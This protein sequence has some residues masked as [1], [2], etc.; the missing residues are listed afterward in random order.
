MI[1][2][3]GLTRD[4]ACQLFRVILYKEA[5]MK[6]ILFLL[7]LFFA[8]LHSAELKGTLSGRLLLTHSPYHATDDITILPGDSLVIDPGVILQFD[9]TVVFKVEGK[10]VAR[11]STT[12][13]ILFTLSA[14]IP[15]GAAWE[16]IQFTNRS[17]HTSVLEFCRIEYARRGVSI[18]SVSPRI[19]HS[20]IINNAMDGILCQVSQSVFSHN[21]IKENG[22]DGIHALAFSGTI[23]NNE[24]IANKGDGISLHKSSGLVAGN[25][26]S[27]NG[28]DGIFCKHSDNM[29]RDNRISQNLDD[30]IL[31]KAASPKILNN[32]LVRNRFGLFVYN[33]AAPVLVNNTIVDNTYGLYA[34]NGATLK[35]DNSIVWRNQ[36][37]VYTDSL[38][39]AQIT[40][41]NI[42]GGYAGKGNFE[43]DPKFSGRE[44]YDLLPGSPCFGRGN[45][46]P[47][48]DDPSLEQKTIGAVFE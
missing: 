23:E 43:A 15:V 35:L 11:G 20:S 21:L 7:C 34:R 36:T 33:A 39:V 4:L 6:K 45:P 47:L 16:G 42:Q 3:S 27:L 1:I 17:D 28:D 38:S 8:A 46:V 9:S 14:K 37:S 2:L 44:S 26:L 12:K 18:F 22:R 48:I 13:N 19:S 30:G 29:I 25:I 41:S 40:F 10:L 32:L 24:I 5:K 31:V